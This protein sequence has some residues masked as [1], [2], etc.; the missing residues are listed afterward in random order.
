M[1]LHGMHEPGGT[2]GGLPKFGLGLL[3]CA[4]SLYFFFDSVHVQTRG[5]GWLSGMMGG[6][7]T[8]MGIVFVPF[9]LGMVAL[10]YDAKKGWAWG[11]MWTGLAILVI[12][13]LSRL[14]FMMNVKSSHLLIMLV[15][16][17]A[18]AGLMLRSYR[19]ETALQQG[20]QAPTKKDESQPD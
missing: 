12:E 19:D 2:P 16:F 18:G 9:F 15:T 3:L 17:A 7:T 14:Q 5:A 20:Q 1:V 10:F 6:Q 11:L 13:I 4:V 8:S